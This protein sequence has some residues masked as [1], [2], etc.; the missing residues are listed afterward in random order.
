[1][2]PCVVYARVSSEEQARAGYSIA[3]QREALQRY[4][5]GKQ[6]QVESFFE[7]VHSAKQDGRPEFNQMVRFLLE[8]PQVRT[9]V[10]HKLDR[11][12]RNLGD[13]ALIRDQLGCRI[14]SVEEPVDDSPAGRL[15]Q[16]INFSMAAYYS[17]NLAEEVKKGM[18]AKF[19]AGECVAQAPV[20]YL[21]I[22]RTRTRPARVVVDRTLAPVVQ[23][24]FE[25]YATGE[26]SLKTMALEAFELGL[27][28]RRGGPLHPQRIK[29]ILGH[30]FYKGLVTYGVEARPGH[31]T[32]L[33]TEK[34]WDRVQLVLVRR[35]SSPRELGRKFFLLRGIL[36][37]ATC[38][39]RHVAEDHPR[40][41]YYRCM[42]DPA[43]PPCSEPYLPVESTNQAV[44][45][46]LLAAQLTEEE[47]GRAREGIHLYYKHHSDLTKIRKERLEVQRQRLEGALARLLDKHLRSSISQELFLSRKIV[48]EHEIREIN[49]RLGFL[50]QDLALLL[51][52]AETALEVAANIELFYY[53][54]QHPEEQKSLLKRLLTLV[55]TKNKN[56]HTIEYEP[57]FNL[58][59]GDRR[60][61]VGSE[62]WVVDLMNALHVVEWER[63]EA[64]KPHSIRR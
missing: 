5:T 53:S 12:S 24:I 64:L 32:P 22:S 26:H 62:R 50:R 56:I 44:V 35:K 43:R 15:H 47:A 57:P 4:T 17:D 39:R 31:H 34:L 61:E 2:T 29:N 9:V 20:G 55:A 16:N 42:P 46:R 27:K 48:I 6:L 37:C 21:N 52:R 3:A 45:E 14:L 63:V 23:H 11:L 13:V 58:L 1:M 7:E 54:Q 28:T 8:H 51:G 30:P 60:V 25:A 10:V 36:L 33:V 38:G 49:E 40:G 59:L 41:S 18:R 19:E